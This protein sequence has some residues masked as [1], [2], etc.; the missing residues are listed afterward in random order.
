MFKNTWSLI[1]EEENLIE[2]LLYAETE[3]DNIGL[4]KCNNIMYIVQK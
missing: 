3:I 1:Y 4:D 2:S